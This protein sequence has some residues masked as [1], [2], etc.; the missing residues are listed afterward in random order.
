M[1]VQTI[2]QHRRDTAANWT[3]TNPTL[4]AGEMGFETDTGIAVPTVNGSA[5][6]GEI[7]ELAMFCPPN[8]AYVNCEFTLVGAGTKFSSQLTTSLPTNTIFMAPRGYH[9]A[10][11][12]STVTGLGLLSLYTES[13]I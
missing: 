4:S 3:S 6:G 10:G 12:T 9:S 7:F 5:V 13:D 1:A 8:A 11:G 2:I